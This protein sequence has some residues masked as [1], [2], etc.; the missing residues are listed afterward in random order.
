[1]TPVFIGIPTF[2][3]PRLVIDAIESVRRQTFTEFRVI[4]SDNRSGGDAADRVM[5]YIA[6]LSDSRFTFYQQPEN[7]GEYGQGRYLMSAAQGFEFFMILHDDDILEQEFLRVSVDTLRRQTDCSLFV[8]NPYI[9]ISSIAKVRAPLVSPLIFFAGMAAS[10]FRKVLLTFF[11]AIWRVVSRLSP[12]LYSG[13][14]R[15]SDPGLPTERRAGPIRS[16]A[17][18]SFGSATSVQ[19][20]GLAVVSCWRFASTISRSAVTSG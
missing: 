11:P 4:V 12:A 10:A 6:G 3:R 5:A 19:K 7:H 20:V 17:T 1:M 2:N 18:Y 8:A 16:N 15:C 9:I 14:R 13:D